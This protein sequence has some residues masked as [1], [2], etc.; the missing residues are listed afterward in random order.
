[1]YNKFF[2]FTEKPFKL[3]PDPVFLFLSKSH[4]EALAHLNYAVSQG[5]G[6]VA[7]T[8]EVGTGKTTLCRAFLEG[9][10]ESFEAAY[11]FN[12][13][14]DAL[15]LLKSIND[16][17]GISSGADNV[18]DLIDTLNTFL[19][20]KKSAGRNII[21][22]IDEAHNLDDDV[23]EQIRLLSNLE[24]TRQKLIQIILLGQPELDDMLDQPKLRQLEQRIALRYHLSPLNLQETRQYIE[25]RLA[26]ASQKTGSQF[27]PGAISQVHKYSAGIPRLINILC[28]RALLIAYCAEKGDVSRATVRKA[29]HELSVKK[30]CRSPEFGKLKTVLSTVGVLCGVALIGLLVYSNIHNSTGSVILQTKS[31]AAATLEKEKPSVV[32]AIEP[33]AT[34]TEPVAVAP[35]IEIEATPAAKTTEPQPDI[36]PEPVVKVVEEEIN[37]A[38]TEETPAAENAPTVEISPLVV[39]VENF[40]QFLTDIDPQSSKSAA[41]TSALTLWGADGVTQFADPLLEDDFAYFQLGAREKGFGVQRVNSGLSLIERLDLP[42]ILALQPA[43][44]NSPV[45][46]TAS[47][48][49]GE[50]VTLLNGDSV[51]RINISQLLSR[52]NGLAYVLWKDHLVIRDV[53][54]PSYTGDAVITLKLLLRN[55]GYDQLEINGVFDGEALTAVRAIQTKYGITPDGIV[56]PLTKIVLYNEL[57]TFQMPRLSDPAAESLS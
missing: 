45:Y 23:L 46:M 51:I 52:W 37:P 1:M 25:H 24:T 2:G 56:G 27:S 13:K 55:I 43:A 48:L 14:L 34:A 7:I 15:Q 5:D 17:F 22:I 12:P 10:D 31:P 18:K 49:Q 54:S 39:T 28:D 9:L 36:I 16:E 6:F 47:R 33:A 35:K 57:N 20:E 21:L 42:V 19:L 50:E 29:I 11:I 44:G 41:L 53:I 30:Q 3:V 38:A 26:I 8:G 32:E 4:E 40:S